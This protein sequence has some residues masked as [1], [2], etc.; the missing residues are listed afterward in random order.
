MGSYYRASF[1]LPHRRCL[2]DRACRPKGR[3]IVSPAD[4]DIVSSCGLAVVE[5]SWARLDEVPFGKISSPHERI[6]GC[7]DHFDSNPIVSCFPLQCLIYSPPIPSTTESPGNLTA[8]RLSPPH[9]I[10]QGMTT[11]GDASC[12]TLDGETHSGRLTCTSMS[13]LTPQSL[14]IFQPIS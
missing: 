11:T 14:N 13:A 10:S 1:P 12:K 5:C 4:K 7:W 2:V 6:R 9:S 8:L 3:D